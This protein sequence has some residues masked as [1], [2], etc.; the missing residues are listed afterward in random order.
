MEYQELVA[1]QTAAREEENARADRLEA[2][3]AQF[4]DTTGRQCAELEARSRE[5]QARVDALD[6][7]CAAHEARYRTLRRDAEK[8]VA[9]LDSPV[10]AASQQDSVAP[11]P[12]KNK[13]AHAVA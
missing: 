2:D 8:L 5:L 6:A 13:A 4:R 7:L 3:L 9:L 11:F 1:E 10:T 12:S